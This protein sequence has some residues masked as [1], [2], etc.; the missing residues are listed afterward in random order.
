[1]IRALTLLCLLPVLAA[2]PALAQVQVNTGALDSLSTAAPAT[3]APSAGTGQDAEAPAARKAR[4]K[5]APVHHPAAKP[6]TAPTASSATKPGSKTASQAAPVK[7]PAPPPVAVAP[8]PP[9]AAAL[10]P[11]PPMPPARP[12]PAPVVPLAD[13]AAGEASP[14]PGGLRVTFGAG[15]AELNPATAEAIRTLG[16]TIAADP[17]ESVNVFAYA[18][19]SPDDPST[20]RRVS[21]SRALA[22]RAVLLGEGIASTRIYPRALGSTASQGPADRVDLLLAGA[23]PESGTP[24]AG[25]PPRAP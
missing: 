15:R 14:I 2:S 13:D 9:P 19:G 23:A 17:N 12:V 24:P 3:T 1:M 7:P 5:P 4:P 25:A 11:P 20:P 8:A 18:A 16:K 22:A 21:L 6:A 10:A